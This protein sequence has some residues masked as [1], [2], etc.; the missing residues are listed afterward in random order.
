MNPIAPRF[1]AHVNDRV[2]FA[3]RPRIED[4]ILP[5]QP[6]R[7]RVHQRIPGVAGFKLALAAEVRHPEA[8]PVGRDP[9]DHTLQDRVIAVYFRL[10]G[11]S[12]GVLV[13]G[14]RCPRLRLLDR[15]EP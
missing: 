5:D 12:P 6:Q 8:I 15:P 4:F 11:G 10:C 2:S 1:R 7:K 13:A 3:R 9:T 14:G